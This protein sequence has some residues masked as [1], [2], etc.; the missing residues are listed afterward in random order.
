MRHL[1]GRIKV[2]SGYEPEVAEAG[3][4]ASPAAIE[5]DKNYEEGVAVFVNGAATGA[6]SA[7]ALTHKVQHREA[8][9]D[10]WAD[11]AVAE[12]VTEDDKVTTIHLD[13]KDMKKYVQLVTVVAFTDGITPAV[14][15]S[16]TLIYGEPKYI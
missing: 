4:V 1:D 2:I 12:D 5:R 16:S 9:G 11:Y 10:A 15:I 3:T 6:P 8:S 7:M 13:A 14:P